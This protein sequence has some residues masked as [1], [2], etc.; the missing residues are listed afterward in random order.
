MEVFAF[1]WAIVA[2]VAALLLW[3][4]AKVSAPVEALSSGVKPSTALPSKPAAGSDDA[5]KATEKKLADARAELSSSKEKLTAKQK[6]LDELK[7][8]A[9]LKARREGKKEQAADTEAKAKG[10]D[11]RDVEIQS[12]RKGMASLESQLNALKRDTASRD[13]ADASSTQRAAADVDSARKSAESER[14]QR[15]RL[16]DDNASLKKTIE[17]LRAT[18]KKVDARPDVPGTALDLKALPPPVVQELARFFRKGEEFERLYTVA[19]SQLQLEKDRTLEIQRRYFAVCRELAVIAGAPAN[20]SEADSVKR[21]EA[22]IDGDVKVAA[23]KAD[24]AAG[25]GEATKKKRRRRRRRKIA[26]EPSELAE[27]E[28]ADDGEEGDDDAEGVEAAD[29]AD[30]ADDKGNS[31][32]SGASAPA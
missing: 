14:E 18:I 30:A 20:A 16:A 17:E 8:Q 3:N 19:Q 29:G 2:T 27:G 12:L 4:K 32:D 26:G 13:A 15:Q 23:P 28:E 1:I 25:E 31:G 6:E 9:K 7:E 24:V 21:A 5:L 22:V 10:P 11:P